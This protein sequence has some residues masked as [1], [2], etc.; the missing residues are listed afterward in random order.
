MKRIINSIKIA[1]YGYKNPLVLTPSNF[2]M[3]CD[4]LTLILTVS[5]EDKHMM[6]HIAAVHPDMEEHQI[7][8]I[9]AGAGIS[10]EPI[11]RI[12]EL[13]EENDRLKSELAKNIK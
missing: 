12:R 5:K 7:V 1:W 2:K 3:L 4:L 13:I 10:A 9:W 6:T 11:K 8:S